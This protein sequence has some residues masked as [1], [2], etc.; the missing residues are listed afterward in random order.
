MAALRQFGEPS[1]I[2]KRMFVEWR[3]SSRGK[4]NPRFLPTFST[5]LMFFITWFV[6]VS[7]LLS[8]HSHE[9]A[10][11]VYNL[12]DYG[13]PPLIAGGLA[14]LCFPQ[15]AIRSSV[16]ASWVWV[17]LGMFIRVRWGLH[18]QASSADHAEALCNLAVGTILTSVFCPTLAGA[19]AY[20]TS[21]WRR[22]RPL[23]CHAGRFAVQGETL[24]KARFHVIILS[25]NPFAVCRKGADDRQPLA[26][27]LFLL[28]VGV[29]S[30]SPVIRFRLPRCL[31][32]EMPGRL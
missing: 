2:G 14:G 10:I 11:W 8:P 22:W 3:H 12:V 28:S 19:T 5:M 16:I 15:R 32:R 1:I 25:T 7:A 23:P 18:W 4:G 13:L 20:L 17:F 21:A 24:T 9:S 30:G 27:Q 31:F 6:S 26:E 29:V